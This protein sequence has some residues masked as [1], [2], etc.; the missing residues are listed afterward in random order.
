MKKARLAGTSSLQN[1][2]GRKFLLT[3]T[4]HPKALPLAVTHSAL[5]AAAH[6]GMNIT[7]A[8][9]PGYEPDPEISQSVTSLAT[10][11]G[12]ALEISHDQEKAARG[13]SVVYAKS[14]ASIET[15]GDEAAERKKREEF[16]NWRV[17]GSL[18]DLTDD[19][20]FMHC[21]PVRRNVVVDDEVLD[22]P[23]CAAYEEAENRI[24]AQMAVLSSI[25][26]SP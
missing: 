18:M 8:C 25:L 15:W 26:S 14:W 13:V 21:L 5:F 17:T 9:P 24:W 20:F 10:S 2:K 1:P 19:A 3:W 16:R 11:N 6:L 22:G 7:L 4:W 23:R 12:G